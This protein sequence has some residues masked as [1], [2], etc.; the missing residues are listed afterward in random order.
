MSRLFAIIVMAITV[1]LLCEC[2]K[3]SFYNY[4]NKESKATAVFVG[5]D[6]HGVATPRNIKALV[7]L[8]SQNL[9][10][11]VPSAF[12]IGGD[13]AERIVLDSGKIYEKFSLSSVINEINYGSRSRHNKF[14][15]TYGSNDA[16]CTDA[17]SAFFSG[18]AALENYYLYGISFAQMHC[19]EDSL[20]KQYQGLDSLDAFGKSAA[21]ASRNFLKW[22][23]S[24]SDHA[25]IVIMSHMPIHAN[26]GDNFGGEIWCKAINEVSRDHDLFLLFGHNHTIE[27]DLDDHAAVDFKQ[28]APDSIP[29]GQKSTTL[30]YNEQDFYLVLPGSS[31]PVQTSA[32]NVFDTIKI[33][34]TY[35]NAGYFCCGNATKIIFSDFDDDGNY[36]SVDIRRYTV[37]DTTINYFGNTGIANPYKS[38]LTFGTSSN[39]SFQAR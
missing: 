8:A 2:G 20:A 13:C 23:N 32:T 7:Q 22:A 6:L 35:L 5:T 30:P 38:D 25:P 14:F 3:S 17:P 19:A 18:P 28:S 33:N 39:Q 34:F 9:N 26:R 16:K 1:C 15:F 21:S 12:L 36:D 24:L 4:T 11:P 29:E 37:R 10:E 27:S 31:I